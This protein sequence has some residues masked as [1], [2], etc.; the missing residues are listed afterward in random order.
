MF[1]EQTS[2]IK[3][4]LHFLNFSLFLF[5]TFREYST[6][7]SIH[8]TDFIFIY[9]THTT[10]PRPRKSSYGE[11]KP[12]YSYVALCAMAI[13]SSPAKMMTLSQIYKFIMDNFPFYRKNSTRW[14]NS[15]RH[16]LS[17]NDCFVKVSKTSEHGGKGNYW[18]LHQDCT[19]MFQDGSFLRRKRRFLSKEDEEA[20]RQLKATAKAAEKERHNKTMTGNW[21][22]TNHNIRPHYLP[23]NFEKSEKELLLSN[24]HIHHPHTQHH[25]IKKENSRPKSFSIADILEKVEKKI[26]NDSHRITS[27]SSPPTPPFYHPHSPPHHHHYVGKS[28]PIL[29]PSSTIKSSSRRCHPYSITTTSSASCKCCDDY[30]PSHRRSSTSPP[31]HHRLQYDPPLPVFIRHQKHWSP[32]LPTHFK[33]SPSPPPTSTHPPRRC[34]ETP[35]SLSPYMCRDTPSHR[36]LH[37]HHG[38]F[39]HHRSFVKCGCHSF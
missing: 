2:I 9:S 35:P 33:H 29:P 5:L 30:P 6:F 38:G 19:E 7:I 21:D 12:P 28:L 26:D 25:K 34:S 23:L 24:E 3:S 4:R 36:S 8:Q 16:N 10:M 18:T 14:Q 37:P 27:T 17:F 15:L 31:S 22:K 11:D 13:H 20:E 39:E 32:P 1:S